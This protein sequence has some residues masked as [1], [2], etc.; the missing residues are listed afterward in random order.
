VKVGFYHADSH[1]STEED[2]AP[3]EIWIHPQWAGAL[4]GYDISLI[5]LSRPVSFPFN[6]WTNTICLPRPWEV[7]PGGQQCVTMGYGATQGECPSVRGLSVKANVSGTGSQQVLNQLVVP[8]VA[9]P[10]C[11]DS[12]H[13]NGRLHDTQIC[14]GFDAGGAGPCNVCVS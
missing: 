9:M 4:T 2:I 14:A 3:A 13:Y 10:V 6:S 5:R 7:L 12:N 1:D 8:I 11:N